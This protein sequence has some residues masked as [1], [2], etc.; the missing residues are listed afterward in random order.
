MDW[1]VRAD[2]IRRSSRRVAS[3]GQPTL[4]R[5]ACCAFLV[6]GAL[7]SADGC[8]DLLVVDRLKPDATVFS[9]ASGIDEHR[10]FILRDSGEWA[11]IW[12]LVKARERAIP[13]VPEID[14]G[15]KMVV[16]VAFGR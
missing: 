11:A 13:P 14:F 9:Q 5:L 15:R 16:V 10:Q 3:Q 12:Q 4:I 8:G 2:W 1:S 6:P 7:A